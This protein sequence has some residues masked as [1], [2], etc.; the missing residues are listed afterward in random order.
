MEEQSVG[1]SRARS[2][3]L[4]HGWGEGGYEGR[5]HSSLH[6]LV[7]KSCQQCCIFDGSIQQRSRLCWLC[8]TLP[9]FFVLDKLRATNADFLPKEDSPLVANSFSKLACCMRQASVADKGMAEN[10]GGSKLQTL[11][12]HK[13]QTMILSIKQLFVCC[14][15]TRCPHAYALLP[16]FWYVPCRRT[17]FLRIRTAHASTNTP[18]C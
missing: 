17:Q 10:A 14:R 5:D 8:D 3:C 2:P 16:H 18:F 9:P 4:R 7:D 11:L 15:R 13:K 12:L 6:F 1:L